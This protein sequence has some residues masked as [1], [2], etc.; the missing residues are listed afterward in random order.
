MPDNRQPP[1]HPMKLF[2]HSSPMIS[3]HRVR[4]KTCVLLLQN[5]FI[6]EKGGLSHRYRADD[7]GHTLAGSIK[8][9]IEEGGKNISSPTLL[10]R[11]M[12]G[13]A[14]NVFPWMGEPG[15][16]VRVLLSKIIF[17]M[18]NL[19]ICGCWHHMNPSHHMDDIVDP[20]LNWLLF[21]FLL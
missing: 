16:L 8:G 12:N 10:H 19:D 4:L 13:T 18:S 3:F 17:H 14:L 7:I 1:S 11:R 9:G 20:D 5:S 15:N 6:C 2:G 21:P